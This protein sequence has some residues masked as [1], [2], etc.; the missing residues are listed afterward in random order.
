MVKHYG[1]S[2]AH[3]LKHPPVVKKS[4]S[5][6]LVL[7]NAVR[8]LVKKEEETILEYLHT[9]SSDLSEAKVEIVVPNK[10]NWEITNEPSTK[11]S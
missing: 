5:Q 9:V 11:N 10:I 6:P 1:A 3:E 2:S 4:I 8:E 7:P